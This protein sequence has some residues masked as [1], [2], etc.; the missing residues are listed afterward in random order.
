MLLVPAVCGGL[1]GA[2]SNI[3]LTDTLLQVSTEEERPTFAAANTCLANIC[4]FVGPLIGT[5]LADGVGITS[6]LVIIAI[7]RLLGGLTFWRMGVGR[8][9]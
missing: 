6:A 8:E 9:R 4:A 3:L 2:G 7:L 5:A 1:F